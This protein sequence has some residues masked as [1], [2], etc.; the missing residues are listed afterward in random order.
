MR[1]GEA[2]GGGVASPIIKAALV[3]HNNMSTF[4][5]AGVSKKI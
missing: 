5:E 1:L 3:T 2:S 4:S